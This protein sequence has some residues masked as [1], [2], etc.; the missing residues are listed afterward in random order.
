MTKK[1]STYLEISITFRIFAENIIKMVTS[2]QFH[3]GEQKKNLK[4][5]NIYENAEALARE[6]I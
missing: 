5:I 2:M 3:T 6:T 1:T 4:E